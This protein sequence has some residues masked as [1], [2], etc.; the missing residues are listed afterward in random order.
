MIFLLT[1]HPQQQLVIVESV[2]PQ[3]QPVVVVQKPEIVEKKIEKVI[4]KKEKIGC[5][6]YRQKEIRI[7]IGKIFRIPQYNP[8]RQE[9][10]K[11]ISFDFIKR[12]PIPSLPKIPFPVFRCNQCCSQAV[13]QK[14]PS[15]GCPC[16]G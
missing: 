15:C 8:C 5:P 11:T 1:A 12:I 13:V 7:D 10:V 16:N 14:K 6:E 4:E 2:P 3:P 9:P